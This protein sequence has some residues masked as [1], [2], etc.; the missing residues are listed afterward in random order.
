MSE[1]KVVA[2]YVP[3]TRVIV[4]TDAD[5][6][7]T[8]RNQYAL[9]RLLTPVDQIQPERLPDGRWR[10][11]VKLAR[12]MTKQENRATW[13]RRHRKTVGIALGVLLAAVVL[14]V[15]GLVLVNTIGVL[16]RTGFHGVG[17]LLPIAIGCGVLWLVLSAKRGH[18]CRGLHCE[19]CEGRH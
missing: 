10:V 6:T 2:R 8:L 12:P 3:V 19:G 11:I 5:L 15:T 7:R 1:S 18:P 16:V 9:G 14:F 13:W 4:G 17:T